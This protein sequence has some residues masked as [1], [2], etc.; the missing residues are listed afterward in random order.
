[1]MVGEAADGP[2]DPERRVHEKDEGSVDIEVEVQAHEPSDGEVHDGDTDS[3]HEGPS[4]IG[5]DEEAEGF[6]KQAG[7][8]EQ[9]GLVWMIDHPAG[10]GHF[11]IAGDRGSFR[12]RI[13]L[14]AVGFDQLDRH[15][16]KVLDPAE[17]GDIEFRDDGRHVDTGDDDLAVI[18]QIRIAGAPGA[19]RKRTTF[20]PAVGRE[21]HDHGGLREENQTDDLI[22]VGFIPLGIK[23]RE[24]TAM[25]ERQ[26]RQDHRQS[27]RKNIRHTQNSK[28]PGHPRHNP[29]LR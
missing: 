24:D 1:M 19:Q 29:R 27:L 16:G 2:R 22:P 20:D 23:K 3:E 15:I 9:A 10:G 21:K 13:K 6:Q 7:S 4:A 28:Y 26:Q 5:E 17:V 8:E 11:V 14:L 18:D 12:F 25:N